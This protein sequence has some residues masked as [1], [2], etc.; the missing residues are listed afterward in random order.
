MAVPDL[1]DRP[2]SQLISLAGRRAVVTGAAMGIGAA[3]AAR[4]AEAGAAVLLADLDKPAA[5]AAAAQVSAR[6]GG[7]VLATQLD[8]ADS[9]SV[10]AA[11]DL[12]ARE[13]GGIDIWVN[14]A[15]VYPSTPL[16]DLSD[17]AWD[18]VLDINLR[19]TFFGCREAA[20]RMVPARPG[21]VIVNLSSIAGIRG[22]QA[23]VAHYVASK[24]G[25]IGITQQVALELAPHG[26]RV[27]AVAPTT[28]IT[29]GVEERSA[30]R[31]ADLEQALVT[32]L[33][34]AGR[35]DDV[36]RVVLFCASDLAMFMTGSTLLVDAGQMAR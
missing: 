26:I 13:F 5:E 4:L 33:G 18:R 12:A 14:N 34:R 36:A 35:P 21:A 11:A 23:G 31:G 3:I 15:G 1:A 22:R 9:A 24:H 25:I 28:I 20:R 19:G 17:D 10:I 30:A 29:P 27:L 6:H 8:V 2:L 7:T 32:P 16:T